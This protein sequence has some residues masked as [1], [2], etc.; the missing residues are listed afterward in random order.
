M[1]DIQLRFGKEFVFVDHGG[2]CDFAVAIVNAYHFPFTADAD[3]FS[4]GD[5]GREGQGEFDD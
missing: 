2:H 1:S 4:Q 5:F 3:A